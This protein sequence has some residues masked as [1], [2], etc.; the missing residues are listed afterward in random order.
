MAEYYMPDAG[1]GLWARFRRWRRTGQLPRPSF[2]RAVQIQ[3]TSLC[4]ARCLFCGYVDSH[5]DLPQGRM[6]EALFRKII[7]ECGRHPVGRISPYLMNEPLLDKDLPERIAYINSRKSLVTKTKINSNGSLLTPEM[8][9][10]LVDAGL[11][12]LWISVQGYSDESYKKSMGLDLGRTLEN[13][14]RFLDI[15]ERKRAKLPKLT[16]T[17]LRTSI[18]EHELDYARKYWADRGVRFKIHNLDNR[19]GKDLSGLGV[20]KPKLRRDCDLFL[21]Q[22]YILYNG[23]MVIC[24]HDWRR[25]VVLGNL[26]ESGLKD[27]WNSERFL[28]LIRA[29]YAGDFS[30]LAICRSCT[31]S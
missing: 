29:Y 25:S 18:V 1:D 31:I 14:D 3:T 6:D 28:G 16:V 12:H 27:I 22:A 11:R 7:D 23:D 24:C 17:T 19:A 2:P 9:E 15:R 26:A 8:S 20:K 10:G 13:I 30:E 5:K 4:N 21:K